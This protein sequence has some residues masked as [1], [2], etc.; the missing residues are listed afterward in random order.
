MEKYLGRRMR[1]IACSP[2]PV[3]EARAAEALAAK[4]ED[5]LGLVHTGAEGRTGPVGKRQCAKVSTRGG[6]GV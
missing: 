5:E 4:R 3:A 1:P 2:N 6:E